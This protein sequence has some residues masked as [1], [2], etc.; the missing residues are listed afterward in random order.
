VVFRAS[1]VD[2]L[3]AIVDKGNKVLDKRVS[4]KLSRTMLGQLKDEQYALLKATGNEPTYT[5]LLEAAWKAFKG[6]GGVVVGGEGLEAGLTPRQ[7]KLVT[8]YAELLRSG[9]DPEFAK[10]IETMLDRSEQ[11]TAA[12]EHQGRKAG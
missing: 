8:R 1:G 12:K 6:A 2:C 9:R 5:D 7:V 3:E 11:D 10:I 4:V